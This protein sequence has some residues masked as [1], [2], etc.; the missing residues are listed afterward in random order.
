M[1]KSIIIP[2]GDSLRMIYL[3]YFIPIEISEV[4]NLDKKFERINS[5]SRR[6]PNVFNSIYRSIKDEYKSFHL[7]PTSWS[8]IADVPIFYEDSWFSRLI[9]HL[10]RGSQN[11]IIL[12]VTLKISDDL[13]KEIWFEIRKKYEQKVE[14]ENGCIRY[15]EKEYIQ[16]EEFKKYFAMIENRGL[17]IIRDYFQDSYF[18][19]NEYHVPCVRIFL[20]IKNDINILEGKNEF[21]NNIG[22][23]NPE[24]YNY[25]DDTEMYN[26]S[27]NM[28]DNYINIF[29]NENK[30]VLE[31]MYSNIETQTF[32]K[33]YH[34]IFP[35][36][37]PGLVLSELYNLMY[38]YYREM[39][40]VKGFFKKSKKMNI[41]S[42]L[43]HYMETFDLEIM[44]NDF[45]MHGNITFSK[46]VSYNSKIID[47]DY[48]NLIKRVVI[49]KKDIISNMYRL[50]TNYL[51]NQIN[52]QM[53]KNNYLIQFILGIL[54]VVS[55]IFAYLTIRK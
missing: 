39:L 27:H 24:Y 10:Y 6:Y 30:L 28:K 2:I 53:S 11:Y 51:N 12:K 22:Y 8:N 3:T 19:P 7:Y 38:K 17:K 42:I 46:R 52:M 43:N 26:I 41:F 9:V 15:I 14:K 13:N 20:I 50:E 5:N 45:F 55:L 54:A 1:N 37:G 34:S 25:I 18:K 32:H 21:W 47:D 23:L 16:K 31:K 49:K 40:S 4:D 44:N 33:I 35:A 36:I 29:V 48:Y